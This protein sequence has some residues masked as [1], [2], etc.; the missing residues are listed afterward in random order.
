MK[1]LFIL[2]AVA[3]MCLTINAQ[4][5]A[6]GPAGYI[7]D[8]AFA[9]VPSDWSTRGTPGAVA[10]ITTSSGLES[11]VQ[12]LAASGITA[13]LTGSNT[14]PPGALAT[15]VYGVAGYVQ[16]RPNNVSF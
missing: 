9:P 8:F 3:I 10:D 15:A 2:P 4:G 13:T 11:A 12:F 5:A 16:T 6:V 7:F 14:N 1:T